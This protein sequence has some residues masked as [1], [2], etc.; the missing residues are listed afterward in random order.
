[1]TGNLLA[2]CRYL[3][4]E[5]VTWLWFLCEVEGGEFQ[6]SSGPIELL[7]ED[8]LVFVG[9]DDDDSATQVK[10]G[11]PTL[12]PEAACALAAGMTVRR[13][14]VNAAREDRAWTFTLDAESLDLRSLKVPAAE[15]EDPLEQLT[16]RLESAE[17]L[18]EAIEELYT[19]FIGLRCSE[20]WDAMET[21]R[22]RDWVR[23]KL[24]RAKADQDRFAASGG[25]NAD[26]YEPSA[27]ID[28]HG[29]KAQP[30]PAAVSEGFDDGLDEE[31]MSEDD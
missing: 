3:G 4:R 10:G 24:E 16:E 23:V 31:E 14:K 15:A 13:A 20:Q 8:N 1:M 29:H 30:V 26:T 5:F 25:V 2:D 21:E 19:Q 27:V 17:E 28:D 6:L 18:R 9:H 7:V 12:R 11:C 22:I